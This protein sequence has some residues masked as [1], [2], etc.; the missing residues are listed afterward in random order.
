MNLVSLAC[1]PMYLLPQ[2]VD[3]RVAA[4]MSPT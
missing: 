4:Y 2:P 1:L 3:P